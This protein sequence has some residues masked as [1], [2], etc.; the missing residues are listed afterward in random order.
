MK[1]GCMKSLEASERK[2]SIL[3]CKVK[4]HESR[5]ETPSMET[6][7]ELQRTLRQT[8]EG[9]VMRMAESLGEAERGDLKGVEE[10]IMHSVFALGR[11]LM[12]QVL[13][14]EGGQESPAAPRV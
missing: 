3:I 1:G 7:N 12:E 8:A 2:R 11:R 10:Q 9:E 13:S 5:E 14:R 6:S 4:R